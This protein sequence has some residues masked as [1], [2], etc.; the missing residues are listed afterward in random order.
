MGPAVA[1]A[2]FIPPALVVF[3][4]GTW[5]N[6][7][8]RRVIGS[9]WDLGTFWPR[10]SHPFAPPCYAERAVPRSSPGGSGG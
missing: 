6:L 2:L 1:V 8:R 3:V 5:R 9:L 4:A 10:S 7:E